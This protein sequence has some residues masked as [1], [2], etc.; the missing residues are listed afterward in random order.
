[1]SEKIF[2]S[3]SHENIIRGVQV[4]SWIEVVIVLLKAYVQLIIQ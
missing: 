3:Q 2:Q 1:M 4:D